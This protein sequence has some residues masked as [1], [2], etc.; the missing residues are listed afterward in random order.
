[1]AKINGEK[2]P[3]FNMIKIDQT[4]EEFYKKNAEQGYGEDYDRQHG[5]RLSSLVQ[6]FKINEWTN[7]RILDIGGGLGFLG[8]RI[9]TS[10][11]YWVLDGAEIPTEKRLCGGEWNKV[12]LDHDEFSNLKNNEWADATFFLETLEHIGNPHHAIVQIKKLTKQN[13]DIF[14]SIP[15]YSVTHNTPYPGLLWP[16]QNFEVFLAQMALPIIEFWD[17]VPQ[18]TGWPAHTYH[19]RNARWIESNMLFHKEEAKF[20]GVTPLQATNL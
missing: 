3:T 15:P 4:V 12:D 9:D 18:N 17:Y 20:C 13:G 11:K 19:C 10:N 7:K 6:H 14:I 2:F 5:Q 16:R 8:R 1:M